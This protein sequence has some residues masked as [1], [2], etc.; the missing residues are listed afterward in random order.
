LTKKFLSCSNTVYWMIGLTTSTRAGPIPRQ[1][2]LQSVIKNQFQ[3]T[4]LD[5]YPGPS[6]FKMLLTV[7]KK[8][9]RSVTRRSGEVPNVCTA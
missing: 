1:K 5:A 7:S 3:Q 2:A 8:P 4:S 9:S 6:F